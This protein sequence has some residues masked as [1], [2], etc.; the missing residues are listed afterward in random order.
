LTLPAN[1]DEA[2][3]KENHGPKRHGTRRHWELNIGGRPRNSFNRYDR[4]GGVKQR[5][6]G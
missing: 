6:L 1:G 3:R 5:R 2:K 4:R